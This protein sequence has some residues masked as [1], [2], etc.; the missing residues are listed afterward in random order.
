MP[1][2][3]VAFN[4]EDLVRIFS[5]LKRMVNSGRVMNIAYSHNSMKVEEFSLSSLPQKA[6]KAI[7]IR[8]CTAFNE[9]VEESELKESQIDGMNRWLKIKCYQENKMDFLIKFYEHPETKETSAQVTSAANW[10]PGEMTYFLD[11]MQ[12]FWAERGLILEAKG[13]YQ[14]LSQ[15]QNQ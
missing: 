6:L 10:T 11:W 5:E 4:Q 12:R 7:W 9:N 2:T 14:E 13:E 8:K 15:R 3:E 1:V